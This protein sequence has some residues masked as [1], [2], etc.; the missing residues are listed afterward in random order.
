MKDE[1]PFRTWLESRIYSGQWIPV[2]RLGGWLG[3]ASC[4]ALFRASS[5]DDV[6]ANTDWPLQLHSAGPEV[7]E[8]FAEGEVTYGA[9][10]HPVE[11]RGEVLFHPF[12]AM[13][14]PYTRPSWLEP[15]QA[16]VLHWDAW[17]KHSPDGAV[18]WFEEGDDSLPDEIARWRVESYEDKRTLG[19]LEIRRDR[20]LAFLAAYELDLAIYHEHNI[21]ANELP[22]GWT[23][24]DR[25]DTRAWTCWAT[26]LSPGEVRAVL[27]AVTI[28]ERPSREEVLQP[29][30]REDR[31]GFEYPIGIDPATGNRVTATHPPH[32]FLTAVFFREA[33]L[34]KY[35]N[36]PSVYV[37]EES[38]VRGGRQWT[39]PIA[40]T[41]RG[42]IQAWLGDVA[43]LPRSVQQHWQA[44]AVVDEGGVPEWRIRTDFLAQ[45]VEIPAEGPIARLK[46]AITAANEVAEQRF[47]HP[48][49]AE[50]DPM[51]AESI[52]VLRIPPNTSIDAFVEQVR[53]LALLVVDHLNPAFLEAANAPPADGTLNRLALVLADLDGRTEDD[54]RELLGGLYAVQ[55]IRSTVVSHRAGATAQRA[56]ERAEIS[57][58]D[59]PTGFVRLVERARTSI[60][61][62]TAVLRS[63]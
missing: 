23:D 49:Y 40:R 55:S 41:G 38:L 59:L 39:L 60:E 5:H 15:I 26:Q 3:P 22:D 56:L 29:W 53:P 47:Q 45:F 44:Y 14:D 52:R 11:K 2:G 51:H 18:T 1:N 13:F 42:T 30:D 63:E 50:V 7:W 43:K 46:E 27:R 4:P 20:V 36:D 9:E 37:V 12:V 21:E 24:E 34:E 48:L 16:F 35:Y 61:A 17:P 54:A 58:Y 31:S 25:E 10:L 62:V 33:V 32:E 28:L 8:S 57:L 19:R 6:L